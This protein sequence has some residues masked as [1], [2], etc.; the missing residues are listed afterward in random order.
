MYAGAARRS[1]AGG[2]GRSGEDRPVRR[3]DHHDLALDFLEAGFNLPLTV[4]ALEA[5]LAEAEAALTA[6]VR[7]SS[8]ADDEELTQ[9][10]CWEVRP[11][12]G[13]RC[14]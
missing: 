11:P 9:T 12:H 6:E 4:E 7:A 13:S 5:A 2:I 14:G 3:T 8:P 10:R 1:P